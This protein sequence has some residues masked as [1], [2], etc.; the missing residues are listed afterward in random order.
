MICGAPNALFYR[1]SK[2]RTNRSVYVEVVP[3]V[4]RVPAEENT[5]GELVL[6][7]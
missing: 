7:L 2:P 5:N 6:V 3:K 1:T 4:G